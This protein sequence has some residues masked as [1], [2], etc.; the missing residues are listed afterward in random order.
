MF[1]KIFA[2]LTL[3][4]G[5]LIGNLASAKDVHIGTIQNNSIDCYVNVQ[6]IDRNPENPYFR[7]KDVQSVIFTNAKMVQRSNSKSQELMIYFLK[8][9]NGTVQYEAETFDRSSNTFKK[10]DHDK[11]SDELAQ[12]VWDFIKTEPDIV[13]KKDVWILDWNGKSI[14]L[15]ARSFTLEE[16]NVRGA[17]QNQL[18]FKCTLVYDDNDHEFYFCASSNG[19]AYVFSK[20]NHV[21][22][23]SFYD[24]I[25]A[26]V[27]KQWRTWYG[28]A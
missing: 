1:R 28:G 26:E 21:G 2:I 22:Y 4:F 5:M 25:Y 27:C 16:A 3:T 10:F 15:K 7:R 11:T 6:S 14:Y 24:S 8:L 12:K 20:G 17:D 19:R 13:P 9:K 23:S 18:A